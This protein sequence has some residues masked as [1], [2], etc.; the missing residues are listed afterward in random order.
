MSD[1]VELVKLVNQEAVERGLDQ[2]EG[3]VEPLAKAKA[4]LHAM[5]KSEK[6]IIA[7]EQKLAESKGVGGVTAQE[8]E[9][10]ASGRYED[11]I[12]ESSEAVEDYEIKRLQYETK[13]ARFEAWRTRVATE[14]TLAG[15]R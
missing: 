3:L 4:H 14:R 13:K 2:M 11:W 10:Y 15:L 6:A 1:G 9:A 7:R 8:R 5:T 12:K